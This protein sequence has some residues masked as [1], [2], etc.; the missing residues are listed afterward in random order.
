LLAA[1]VEVG[2]EVGIVSRQEHVGIFRPDLIHAHG[3]ADIGDPL[4]ILPEVR[5]RA[6]DVALIAT[7][8]PYG[9]LLAHEASIPERIGFGN[10]L[11][12]PFKGAWVR[13]L[14]TEIRQRGF[15]LFPRHE[16]EILF[17]LGRGRHCDTAPT[18]DEDRLRELFFRRRVPRRAVLAV[19]ITEKWRSYGIYPAFLAFLMELAREAPLRLIGAA[20]EEEFLAETEERS[21][22]RV[23]RHQGM[24][25]WIRSIASSR[26]LLT[27]DTGA[28]HV[29][30]MVGTS[31]IDVFPNGASRRFKHRWQPWAS[32]IV[33]SL[34]AM[35]LA[36]QDPRTL[37]E[38]VMGIT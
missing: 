38:A 17:D 26:A 6:Y 28:A 34:N 14:C 7:E 31:V 13:R 30:G 5:A 4:S 1:L 21:G 22:I 19:Q 23:K 36:R 18:F 15:S 16:V 29:A 33:V 25:S 37:Y 2:H 12:K 9:Y 27:P 24:T 11:I 10:G 3:V 32:P 20:R 35:M 8:K